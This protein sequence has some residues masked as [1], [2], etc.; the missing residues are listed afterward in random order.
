MIMLVNG[1]FCAAPPRGGKKR[2]PKDAI[3]FSKR[4][5]GLVYKN[6]LPLTRLDLLA[7][8][9]RGREFREKSWARVAA[10][11][12]ASATHPRRVALRAASPL[13][14]LAS[15]CVNAAS[16]VIKQITWTDPSGI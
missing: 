13:R 3:T 15:A 10:R 6:Y 8:N 2:A 1:D 5:N 14:D 16:N 4:Q 7:S 12:D 11:R 9:L